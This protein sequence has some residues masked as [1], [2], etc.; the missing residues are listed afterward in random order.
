LSLLK[1]VNFATALT[2]AFV[3]CHMQGCHLVDNKVWTT[4]ETRGLVFLC[5]LILCWCLRVVYR[6]V[7]KSKCWEDVYDIL[8]IHS[9]GSN[10]KEENLNLGCVTSNLISW[11]QCSQDWLCS[12]LC[13]SDRICGFWKCFEAP[14][15]VERRNI[16]C[17]R[18]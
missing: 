3:S 2:H 14:W 1:R 4:S 12:C 15:K 17:G 7:Y 6:Y 10:L 18:Y 13:V 5:V 11:N 16:S 8:H 9:F